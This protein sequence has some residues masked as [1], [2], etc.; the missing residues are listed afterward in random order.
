MFAEIFLLTLA[1]IWI[2]FATIQDLKIR[3]VANWLNFSLI[4]FALG[5]RFFYSF[6]AQTNFA[7]FYQG[8]IGFV[9]FFIF[10]NIFYYSRLFA[11]GDAK[12]FMAL[13]AILPLHTTLIE[14]IRLFLNFFLIFLF[15]GAIYGLIWSTVLFIR[16]RKIFRKKFDFLFNKNRKMVYIGM[17]LGIIIMVLSFY[18]QLF[19]FLGIFIFIL[20]FLFL[21]AKAIDESCMVRKVKTNDLREGD[22]LC[23]NIKIGKKL[24]KAKWEGLTEKEII[25]LKKKKKFVLIKQG[26]PFVPVFLITFILFILSYYLGYSFW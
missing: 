21:Y 6:F 24:I 12:L 16:N 8:L 25:L 17:A 11:G 4:I 2:L 13:G 22:W 15:I 14:N 9:L 26:I 3:E 10:G 19:F 5:F 20:P 18:Q 23:S 1:L 7:F